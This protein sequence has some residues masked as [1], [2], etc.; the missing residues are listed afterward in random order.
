MSSFLLWRQGR[1]GNPQSIQG[2]K[3]NLLQVM[4]GIESKKCY[5]IVGQ[6]RDHKGEFRPCI[7]IR[8]VT[9]IY[10]KGMVYRPGR[11]NV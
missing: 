6:N 10:L 4:A 8:K 9:L 7:F 3:E 1:Q 5:K 11:I 2:L